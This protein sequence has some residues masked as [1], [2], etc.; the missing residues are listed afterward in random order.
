MSRVYITC[1]NPRIDI[2]GPEL[3]SPEGQSV[4]L[5]FARAY[6]LQLE[7]IVSVVT[8]GY[9]GCEGVLVPLLC[10]LRRA[11]LGG[12]DDPLRGDERL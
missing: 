12:D 10:F 11:N 2:S 8:V 7:V 5:T 4:S 1:V 6:T 9:T 3:V